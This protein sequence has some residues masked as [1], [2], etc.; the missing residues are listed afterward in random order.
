M[1]LKSV[2]TGKNIIQKLRWVG[3][4][5]FLA[6]VED[7]PTSARSRAMNIYRDISSI[8]CQTSYLVKDRALIVTHREATTYSPQFAEKQKVAVRHLL[9]S[10][11]NKYMKKNVSALRKAIC[12]ATPEEESL[13]FKVFNNKYKVELKP[14][15][16]S[17]KESKEG[18]TAI[19]QSLSSPLAS[20]SLSTP[21]SSAQ[22]S[23]AKIQKELSA[24]INNI[25]EYVE[26]ME[27]R[28]APDFRCRMREA[29]IDYNNAE[30]LLDDKML[31]LTS[32]SKNSETELSAIKEILKNMSDKIPVPVSNPIE[33]RDFYFAM[34][35]STNSIKQ[36]YP[37]VV[38]VSASASV[39][40]QTSDNALDDVVMQ[41]RSLSP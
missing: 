10:I 35:D 16:K 32:D 29:I 5:I 41:P 28:L 30:K 4:P 33:L 34:L 14:L 36:R 17:V 1:P 38:S 25:S 23:I 18:T 27:T 6:I 37:M 7:A 19:L 31:S 40:M 11:A 9:T 39:P 13:I 21:Q 8:T 22:N 26:A 24:A 3:A 2:K 15:Q 12:R 20:S